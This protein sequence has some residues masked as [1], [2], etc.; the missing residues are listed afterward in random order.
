M[1]RPSAESRVTLK[2][3]LFATDFSSASNAALPHA[4]TI[5]D[6]YRSRLYFAHVIVPEF[7]DFAAAESTRP[8]SSRPQ[9]WPSRGWNLCSPRHANKASPAKR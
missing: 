4:L 1:N 3:I 5:A 6:R 2:D 9:D 8:Y 7:K